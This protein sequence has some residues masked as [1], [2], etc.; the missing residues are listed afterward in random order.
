MELAA[1]AVEAYVYGYP[2]VRDLSV[3]E[4]FMHTGFGSLPP[5]PFNHFAHA[6]RPSSADMPFMSADDTVRS[7]V[8]LDLSG[9]PVLLRLP[10]TDGA[11]GAYCVFQ[12]VDA[13][14]NSF[15]YVGRRAAGARAGDWLVVP[16]GWAGSVPDG[17]LGVVDAPTSVVSVIGRNICADSSDSEDPERGRALR[18]QP[19]VTYVEPGTHRT[20]LPAPDPDVPEALRFFERLR[21]WMADFPPSAPDQAY[22]DRFQP[23]GLL[24][25]GP[26]PYTRADPALVRA[27]TGGLARGRAWV[28]EA[29]RA[30]AARGGWVLDPHL[31][32]YNLDHYGVGTIDSPQWRI[33]DRE[34]SYRTR[35]VAARGSLWGVHGYEAVYAHTLSDA[36]G[37]RLNG[38]HSYVLRFEGPPPVGAGWSLAVYDLA[39][40]RIGQALVGRGPVY[41]EE[42][43]S[44]AV[45]IGRVW[46]D[47]AESAD[48]NR[49]SAPDGD[50]RLV[51]R[52]CAP[53]AGMLD[54]TYAIPAVERTR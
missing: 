52:L 26:S 48:A 4:G 13:W 10:G 19:G 47:A 22:Q 25:E 53:G 18:E 35:A 42:D 17:V 41:G 7:V 50:F 31:F 20:G 54:G 2:L 3:V 6:G 34:A 16:P 27:L 38:A 40:Q 11:D 43:G 32:D 46:P 37:E 51:L 28:E 23:L 36:G 33:A 21:V 5:T 24:E 30:A 12:F 44:P 9:G 45:R 49:L 14:T 8:Q 39:G 15:A 29:S 1:L